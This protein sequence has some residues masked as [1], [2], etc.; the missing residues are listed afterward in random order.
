MPPARRRE[1]VRGRCAYTSPWPASRPFR[2]LD[3]M[4]DEVLVRRAVDGDSEAFAQLYERYAP[5]LHDFCSR[6]LRDPHAA[7]DA[8]HD[9]FVT[10][11]ARLHQLRDPSRVRPWLYAIAR[12]T[13]LRSL[14]QAGRTEA[15]DREM[16]E[17]SQLADPAADPSAAA[18]AG[19][20]RR[21]FDDAA[22][23]L[24]PRDRAILELQLRHG[25]EGADLADAMGMEPKASYVLVSRLRDQVE[26]ALGALLV[27]REG[28]GR[29]AELDGVLASW[30]GRF[31]PLW[32]KRVGRHA[33]GCETCSATRAGA[34]NPA[35]L[36]G[37]IPLVAPPADLRD[38]VLGEVRLVSHTG[39]PWP[40]KKKRARREFPPA[41][42]SAHRR[43]AW[44]SAAAAA[45]ALAF[46]A[47]NLV[48]GAGSDDEEVAV[49][50]IGDVDALDAD[51][52]D[53][54]GDRSGGASDGAASPGGTAADGRGAAEEP[55]GDEAPRQPFFTHPSKLQGLTG[56]PDAAPDVDSGTGEP[57][58][59]S[60][61]AD[62]RDEP[63][64]TSG[65]APTAS[66]PSTTSTTTS[67]TTTTTTTTRPD[68]TGP[69]LGTLQVDPSRIYSS[70][71]G[72]GCG[73]QPT[74][75]RVSIDATD[76]SGVDRVVLSWGG[77]EPGTATMVRSGSTY[78]A[79]IGD[80]A[81]P[82]LASGRATAVPLTIRADDAAG[83]RST[84]T[85]SLTLIGC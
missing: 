74:T 25:L 69:T 60:P 50:G 65:T 40:G 55:D 39:G 56:E 32:R 2:T 7:A 67:T 22:S 44:W 47:A 63:P 68:T 52:A 24:S 17:T 54:D 76:P 4:E 48:V 21:L 78:V 64:T 72:Q 38:R 57:D 75:T 45:A 70:V 29:C 59:P 41:E 31:S 35:A 28:R 27:A 43:R 37:A 66:A 61:T 18:H 9:T 11:G 71:R 33:D 53:N 5:R 73:S 80:F 10:A 82:D 62:P 15:L 46:V 14:E 19:E 20:L 34:L 58:G 83:N 49:R 81:A 51:T 3:A 23:G 42:P 6:L 85:G 79:T 1:P 30:D 12:H 36:L 26:R 84:T 16:T 13:A 77:P 8:C